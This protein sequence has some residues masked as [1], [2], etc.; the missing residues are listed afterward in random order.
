MKLRR[1]K[2]KGIFHILKPYLGSRP[3]K[4]IFIIGVFTLGVFLHAAMPQW[5]FLF[6]L[7]TFHR[8]RLCTGSETSFQIF[9]FSHRLFPINRSDYTKIQ[10]PVKDKGHIGTE[11]RLAKGCCWY[12]QNFAFY[13]C[14]QIKY[15]WGIL[16]FIPPTKKSW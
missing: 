6:P 13:K 7:N 5:T 10:P 8:F 15:Y 12:L 4:N 9:P 16:W 14:F 11:R 1:R 3:T 2:I